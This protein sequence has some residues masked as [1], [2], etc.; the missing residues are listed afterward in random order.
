MLYC[1]FD[2]GSSFEL[3]HISKFGSPCVN[4]VNHKAAGGYS[5]PDLQ[6]GKKKKKKKM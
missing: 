1:A 5:G 3:T 4:A 2:R 6:A